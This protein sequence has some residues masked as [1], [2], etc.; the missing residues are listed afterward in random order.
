[1]G[2]FDPVAMM[3]DGLSD[4]PDYSTFPDFFAS[5]VNTTEIASYDPNGAP[6]APSPLAV[7]N[8]PVTS[9]PLSVSDGPTVSTYVEPQTYYHIPSTIEKHPLSIG[10]GRMF[11]N[12]GEQDPFT[13]PPDYTLPQTLM[14]WATMFLPAVR[15]D[16]L[17]SPA[18]ILAD[19][20]AEADL[21]ASVGAMRDANPPTI[22]QKAADTLEYVQQMGEPPPGHVGGKPF[23]NDGRGDGRILPTES[24]GVPISYKEY[25]VNPYTPGVNRGA[26]RIVVGSDGRAW[27]TKDHYGS[28]LQMGTQ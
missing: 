15:G 18:R 24:G 12:V 20:A 26:E 9:S 14:G 19:G 13:P 4:T 27:Y 5:G 6:M 11:F 28:F 7:A 1:M 8:L 10:Q 17:A 2:G 3:G 22:P 23:L 16:P 21:A 25:D